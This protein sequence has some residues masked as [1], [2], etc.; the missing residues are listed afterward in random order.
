MIDFAELL[1][2]LRVKLRPYVVLK[3]VILNLRSGTAFRGVVYAQHG[4]WL[5]LR[6][7]SIVSDRGVDLKG[8]RTVD[9]S[10]LVLLSDIDFV[11]VTN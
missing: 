11:Q 9:G 1:D 2:A 8:P 3:Q 4:K 5:E 7:A 10:V 6:N